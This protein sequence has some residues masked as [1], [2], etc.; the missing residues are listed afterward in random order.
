MSKTT[1]IRLAFFPAVSIVSR[2]SLASSLYVSF[3]IGN[4]RSAAIPSIIYAQSFGILLIYST[5]P[6]ILC[7]RTD[8]A[9]FLKEASA[10]ASESGT[11]SSGYVKSIFMSMSRFRDIIEIFENNYLLLSIE[12]FLLFVLQTFVL[13][14]VKPS[15]FIF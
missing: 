9:V 10:S 4:W 1:S 12:T 15:V 2:N 5:L 8:L 14:T 11:Q 13:L 7:E 6:S 3:G